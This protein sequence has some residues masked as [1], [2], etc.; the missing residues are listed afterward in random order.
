VA[1]PPV[2]VLIADDDPVARRLLALILEREGHRSEAARDGEEAWRMLHGA[3]FDV[4]LLDVLMPG[5]DGIEVLER[6][7]ADA[8]LRELPVIMIS[9]LEDTQIVVRCIECGAL[10]Y[11]TKPFNP[12]LLRARMNA[13]LA[14]KRLHEME[15][16]RVRSLFARFVPE[17]VVDQVLQSADEN[18][19][20]GGERRVATVMFADLRGFTAFAEAQPPDL[21]IEV[22]NRY[23]GTMSDLILDHGGT[24]ISY[25]GD[26]M[27]A[28]FGAPLEQPDHADRAFDA[29]R[30]MLRDGL[31]CFNAWIIE[32]ALGAGFRMGVGLNSGPVMAGNVGSERR[33]EYAAVGD[34]TNT[35]ARLEAMTKA[36]PHMLLLADSTRS[37]MTRAREDLAPV[38]EITLRGKERSVRVWTLGAT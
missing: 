18:L 27:M 7:Q 35:A 38:D 3:R 1:G 20:L 8:H 9:A 14:R 12:V 23:L 10:D 17:P 6:M 24:L 28:V 32:Q 29:A 15:R 31:A 13:G 37:F 19:R 16:A 36:T 25:M 11:L 21:V 34:T 22:L 33:L 4:V 26:G 5:L 30:A 2:S